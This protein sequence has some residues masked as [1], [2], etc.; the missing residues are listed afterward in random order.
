LRTL[1]GDA[2]TVRRA[3]EQ[4]DGPVVLAGHSYGGAVITVAGAAD[5]VVAL[6]YVA[7]YV[8]DQGESPADLDGRYPATDLRDHLVTAPYPIPGRE[9]GTDLSVA[10]DAFLP[11]FAAGMDPRAAE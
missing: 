9:D 6:V 10:P 1:D 8:P 7:G 2:A 4:I 5:N 11:V 3:I